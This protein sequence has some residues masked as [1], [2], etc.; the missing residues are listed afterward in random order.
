MAATKQELTDLAT[1][2]AAELKMVQEKVGAT[3]AEILKS[4][5]ET[6]VRAKIDEMA[7]DSVSKFTFGRTNQSGPRWREQVEHMGERWYLGRNG[8]EDGGEGEGLRRQNE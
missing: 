4:H 5:V 7:G 8:Q 3:A 2:W 1:Q 6:M